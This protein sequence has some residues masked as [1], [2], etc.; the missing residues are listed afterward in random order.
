[1]NGVAPK[2]RIEVVALR[3]I[4]AGESVEGVI[5]VYWSPIQRQT[6]IPLRRHVET[7]PFSAIT[8]TP[9]GACSP[10]LLNRASLRFTSWLRKKSSF[11]SVTC[12]MEASWTAACKRRCSKGIET[13][14]RDEFSLSLSTPRKSR[15]PSSY[16]LL[17]FKPITTKAHMLASG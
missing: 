10:S 2:F 5:T 13:S 4:E 12:L 14:A 17:G 16:G 9:I 7:N 3:R 15:Y 1:M 11:D 6:I 8:K